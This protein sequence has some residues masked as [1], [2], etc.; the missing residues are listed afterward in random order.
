MAAA[1]PTP[2]CTWIAPGSQL[3]MQAPHSIQAG[4][5]TIRAT[6]SPGSKTPWGQTMLHNPQL[7]HNFG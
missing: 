6:V 1:H 7:V 2:A 5:L 4:R 3:S